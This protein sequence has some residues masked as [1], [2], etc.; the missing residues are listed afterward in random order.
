MEG[1]PLPPAGW[2]GDPHGDGERW[3]NGA[4]WDEQ[5]RR[6]P[7]PHPG[8]RQPLALWAAAL[9]VVGIAIGS[10]GPWAQTVLFTR[11]GLDLDGGWFLAGSAVAVVSLWAYAKTRARAATLWPALLGVLV[12]GDCIRLYSEFGS[13]EATLFGQSFDLYDPAW[14]IYLCA[15][16]GAALLSSAVLL[17]LRPHHGAAPHEVA[18]PAR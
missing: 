1:S 17:A 8:A 10:L 2:Y 4:E 6:D 5:T 14:G 11:S 13:G 18:K 9:S 12:I 15:I 16:G 7:R 3:W